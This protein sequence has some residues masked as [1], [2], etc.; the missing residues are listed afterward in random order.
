MTVSITSQDLLFDNQI[1]SWNGLT[2]AD[3]DGQPLSS[4]FTG[5]RTVQVQGTFGSG[6]T[7]VIEGTL[8]NQNWYV[9]KDLSNSSL[10]FTS[11]GLRGVLENVVSIR[12]RVVGGNGTTDINVILSIRK[13]N[14]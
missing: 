12:P 5:D 6:G 11:A 8:D 1:C 10:S 3:P 2:I 7:L 9:L 14:A 4:A 13:R